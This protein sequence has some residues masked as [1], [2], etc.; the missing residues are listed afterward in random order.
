MKKKNRAHIDNFTAKDISGDQNI[1][2]GRDLNLSLKVD[3]ETKD[4]SLTST[5]SDY[6]YREYELCKI[7]DE[8]YV[9]QRIVDSSGIKTDALSFLSD[10]I[11][12]A[13]FILV[14]GV[15]GIGKST[16]CEKLWLFYAKQRMK[17]DFF[18]F[19]P[20]IIK[21][22]EYDLSVSA[23]SLL[24]QFLI[25]NNIQKEEFS[26]LR[27][28]TKVILLLDGLDETPNPEIAGSIYRCLFNLSMLGKYACFS[29]LTVR[30]EYFRDLN[31]EE[32][33]SSM[34]NANGHHLMTCTLDSFNQDDIQKYL[35][36]YHSSPYNIIG[37]IRQVYDL[38]GLSSNPMLLNMISQIASSGTLSVLK[39][40]NRASLY[41]IFLKDWLSKEEIR[42]ARIGCKYPSETIAKKLEEIAF[43][44]YFDRR[45]SLTW[46]ELIGIDGTSIS[47]NDYIF[48]ET[49]LRN[50]TLLM[51]KASSF[52]FIHTSFLEY[53]ASRHICFLIKT[54]RWDSLE[55]K[56]FLYEI[57]EFLKFMV[58]DSFREHFRKI[59]L[60]PGLLQ[61]KQ[62]IAEIIGTSRLFS[63]E[64]ILLNAIEKEHNNLIRTEALIS[65]GYL[66]KKKYLYDYITQMHNDARME[67]E[68]HEFVLMYYGGETRARDKLHL[69]LAD[70]AF[71][72]VRA[73]HIHSL[74]ILGN[75][76]SIAILVPF[77]DYEDE[78]VR[79]EAKWAIGKIRENLS[80][81][82][83]DAL[84]G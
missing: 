56:A 53:F 82:K 75:Q 76:K 36:Y 7:Q 80:R 34:L 63:C 57:H 16:L 1:I 50:N 42:I 40:T 55:D 30:P 58:D 18:P 37:E 5:L 54:H 70:P 4:E 81:G 79:I 10:L 17:N 66:G 60:C 61:L 20:I 51:R 59:Y 12:K 62:A 33:M 26:L 73:F 77:L 68:N 31:E 21:L 44:M 64:D 84:I 74:G 11:D 46:D 32:L 45:F 19:F 23:E 22:C 38:E 52:A 43:R 29:L 24:G 3:S 48:W 15:S 2:I 13:N 78:F 9:Q 65:L 72:N 71:I 41:D 39:D 25:R 28:S 83:K 6:L 8:C 67:N 27:K 47:H 49:I 14:L 69:R 35:S